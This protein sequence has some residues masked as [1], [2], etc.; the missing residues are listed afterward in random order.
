[1]EE[2]DSKN[3]ALERGEPQDEAP[4]EIQILNEYHS[5]KDCPKDE[6]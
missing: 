5:G 2:K 6:N 4:P 1:M 3:A